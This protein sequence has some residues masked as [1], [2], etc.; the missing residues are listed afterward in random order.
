MNKAKYIIFL[1]ILTLLAGCKGKDKQIYQGLPLKTWIIRLDAPEKEIR[2]DAM[3]VI[4]EI[5]EPAIFAEPY[6]RQIARK[7]P[8]P[9]VKIHAIEA[10]EAINAPTAEFRNFIDEYNAPIIP[11]EEEMFEVIEEVSTEDIE[12]FSS[13]SGGDDLEFLQDFEAGLLDADKREF[14]MF[15]LDSADLSEWVNRFQNDAIANIKNQ[16]R[17]PSVLALLLKSGNNAEKLF[18]ANRLAELEGSNSQVFE[19][20]ENALDDSL[21]MEAVEKALERWEPA[22]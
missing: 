16:L 3:K 22:E 11:D 13:G 1:I 12:D 17:N 15:P 10:L 18:A 14:G 19:A 4:A 9:E 21:V 6:L 5:G 20:L 8:S 7:D 2:I